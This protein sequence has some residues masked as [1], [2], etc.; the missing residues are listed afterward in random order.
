MNHRCI[1]VI[2]DQKGK[3]LEEVFDFMKFH[4]TFVKLVVGAFVSNKINLLPLEI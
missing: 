1:F 4:L 3:A 2:F